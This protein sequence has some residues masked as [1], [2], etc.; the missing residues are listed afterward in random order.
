MTDLSFGG[1]IKQKW[2][3][4]AGLLLLAA[5]YAMQDLPGVP[6]SLVDGS[7]LPLW[8]SLFLIGA[9]HVLIALFFWFRLGRVAWLLIGAQ[10]VLGILAKSII[11]I[12]R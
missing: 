11:G 1:F 8:I 10:T 9:G 5:W 3:V 7:T 4:T 2:I 12:M 6:A